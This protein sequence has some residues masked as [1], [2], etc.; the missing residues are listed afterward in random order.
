[1]VKAIKDPN[2]QV[3]DF[4]KAAR[5]LGADESEERFREALRTVAKA[6]PQ[7]SQKHKQRRPP[8]GVAQ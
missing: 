1:M 4:R 8:T 7:S 3:R 2:R 6:K 5:D